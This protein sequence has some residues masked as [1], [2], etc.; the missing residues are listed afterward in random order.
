MRYRELVQFEAI[1]DIIQLRSADDREV[2]RQHVRTYVISDHMA[3]NLVDVVIPQ[4]QFERPANNKGILIVGNYGTGKSHLMSVLSA[5]AEFPELQQEVRHPEV[6]RAMESIAGKFKVWRTELGGVT[7]SLRDILLGE[8]E[9]ALQKWGTPYHFPP[10]E[11]LTNHKDVLVQAVATLQEKYPG[12]GLLLVVD[13]LLDYLRTREERALILDLAF[14]R[15]LGEVTALTPFRFLAGLQ[16]TLF[17]NPRFSFVSEQLRRVKDRFEQVRIAREDIAYVV[18]ERLLQKTDAQKAQIREHLARFQAFYPGLAERMDEFVRMFP[19]HPAYIEVLENVRV[20][21]KRQVLRTLSETIQRMLDD[22]VPTDAPGT[23]SFDHYWQVLRSNPSLRSIPEIAEVIDKSSVLEDRVEH[24]FG[25]PALKPMARRIIHALS[26]HRL[27][28][29]DI[30]RPLGMTAEELRDS[31]FLLIPLPEPDAA[32]L[33]EQVEV[34][35]REIIRTVS[36]QYI[37]RNEANGQYYLDVKK[38]IDFEAKIQERGEFLSETDLNRYF[39]EALRQVLNFSTTTYVTG[40]RI[41]FHELPWE[42]H[43]VTRPGYFFFGPPDERSTAQPPRD[44]YVYF[45][46]PFAQRK[47]HDEQRADEVIFSLQG[48]DDEFRS[49]LRRYAGAQAL[50]AESPSYRAVYQERANQIFNHHLLPWLQQHLLTHLY[51]RY[52][53]VEKPIHAVLP[54]LSNTETPGLVDLLNRAAAHLLAPAFEERYPEYP[55]FEKAQQPITESSRPTAAL[56]ALRGILN[57]RP[58]RLG[59]AV[60]HGLGLLDADGRLRPQNSP[61]ARHFL[62]LLAQ[63]AENQV[64]HRG[65]VLEKAAN[66]VDRVIYKDLRFGLEAE[67]VIVILAALV[68][69]GDII[70]ALPGNNVLEADSLERYQL[71]GLNELLEF[72]HYSRPRTL[73]LSLWKEVF[74]LLGL[75]PGLIQDESKRN[76]AVEELQK[77]VEEEL[78]SVTPLETRLQNLTLWNE[79]ILVERRMFTSEGGVVI[80]S[81]TPPNAI[82]TLDFKPALRGYKKF[83]DD[84]AKINAVGKLRHLNLTPADLEEIK[85]WQATIRRLKELL[86]SVNELRPLTDYLSTA[87]AYL[88]EA[89][90]WRVEAAELRRRTLDTLRQLAQGHGDVVAVPNLKRELEA[91]KKRYKN[92]YAAEHRRLV[93]SPTGDRRRQELYHDRRLQALKTLEK[94]DLLRENRSQLQS[95]QS[96][97]SEL[98]SCRDFH[99]GLLDD[100]PI[101]P[102]CKLNPA[103]LSNGIPPETLLNELD[104]QLT[105]LLI[106]WRRA[107]QDA[108]SGEQ[109]QASLA[110]MTPAERRP[111]EEFLRQTSDDPNIPPD[112]AESANRALH[113]IRSLR[114]NVNDLLMALQE[115]GLPCT[116]DELKARFHRFLQNAL[117]GYDENNTRLTLDT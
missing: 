71:N 88:S 27:T 46:E 83:L 57:R 107:L 45:L 62:D 113:G 58:T 39:F 10:A 50:T 22:E 104:E 18:S 53:G 36:G 5:V 60:L 112:F 44:F 81:T 32:F 49:I 117:R 2:A 86:E 21:E 63:R 14:L 74:D 110:A 66:L 75:P 29:D 99:E 24:A 65:E 37:S 79:P 115:G 48:L 9:K 43:K 17:D 100:S 105:K 47:F 54:E 38:D 3:R 69:N 97:I 68:Y 4:L 13:E 72:T 108:L 6:A 64:V 67:W 56:E 52:Q 55:R 33:L 78:K 91:L 23:I 114:L 93:L 92:A 34:S 103:L 30:Y 95:W 16:E 76:Q 61:Y 94:V 51:V 73:P 8:L 90:S 106:G 84:L 70:L 42:G 40:A 15:E 109:A 101:C 111:V 12:Q 96:R 102:H 80:G 116:V 77:R 19:V 59:E 35:L 7:R 82:S 41:W 25:R 87:E 1:T 26:V 11:H 85:T 98:R 31:L 28:T 89:H 20:V